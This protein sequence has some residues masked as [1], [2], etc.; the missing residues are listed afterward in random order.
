MPSTLSPSTVGSVFCYHHHHAPTLM[1]KAARYLSTFFIPSL[2]VAAAAAAAAAWHGVA[3]SSARR[4][5][6][7]HDGTTGSSS[8][9]AATAP[10]PAPPPPAATAAAAAAAATG[11]DGEDRK[12]G[13]QRL[14]LG[15][16]HHAPAP[17]AP[18]GDVSVNSPYISLASTR[19]ATLGF[20][21]PR[22]DGRSSN[23]FLVSATVTVNNW[24][25]ALFST[26]T[27]CGRCRERDSLRHF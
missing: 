3:C 23:L 1:T 25:T 18:C 5:T 10:A 15:V 19:D 21:S 13:G 22:T 11:E 26:L 17:P 20:W 12:R 16:W 8:L 14:S 24:K 7:R 9:V 27:P 6:A 2:P 4:V